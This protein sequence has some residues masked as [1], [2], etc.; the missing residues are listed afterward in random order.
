MPYVPVYAI[1][2]QIFVTG[3]VAPNDEGVSAC[4]S[5]K[6]V[7]ARYPSKLVPSIASSPT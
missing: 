1:G 5:T 6:I 2:S 3:L 4:P 7:S